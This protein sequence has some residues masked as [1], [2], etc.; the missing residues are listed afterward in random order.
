MPDLNFHIEY[1]PG[2]TAKKAGTLEH[3]QISQVQITLPI[4]WQVYE[5]DTP[6]QE[7]TLVNPIDRYCLLTGY[8]YRLYRCSTCA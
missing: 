3:L 8:V 5:E 1:V 7:D 6:V 2:C 4:T